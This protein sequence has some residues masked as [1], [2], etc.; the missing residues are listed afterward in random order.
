MGQANIVEQTKESISTDKV[1]TL[2]IHPLVTA[3]DYLFTFPPSS[4]NNDIATLLEIFKNNGAPPWAK[5]IANK[6]DLDTIKNFISCLDDALADVVLDF[7]PNKR[8]LVHKDILLVRSE[9]FRNMFNSGMAESEQTVINMEEETFESLKIIKNYFYTDQMLKE[10][11]EL[12]SL[13]LYE[14]PIL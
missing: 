10:E 11:K 1:R 4:I 2:Q 14:I 13:D 8:I 9:Y 3:S 6:T 7:G 12:K 5:Q